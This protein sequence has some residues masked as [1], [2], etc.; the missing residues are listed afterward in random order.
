MSTETAKPS[1]LPEPARPS[2]AR[3]ELRALQVTAAVLVPLIAF[4]PL[5][6]FPSICVFFFIAGVPCPGC[7]FTRA[8]QQSFWLNLP[9]ALKLHPF[10]L[11]GV[12]WL[13]L[14]ILSILVRPLADLYVERIRLVHKIYLA[15]TLAMM[16]FG[17][18]RIIAIL[19]LGGA[20]WM[21]PELVGP[22]R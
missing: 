1:G 13:A 10:A 18:A 6:K 19:T 5:S 20:S 17:L 14:L 4:L 21:A 8:L 7:G 15:G 9:Q 12:I 3:I 16:V 11:P 22:G 2:G